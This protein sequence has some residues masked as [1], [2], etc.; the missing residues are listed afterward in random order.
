MFPVSLAGVDSGKSSTYISRTFLI[1]RKN[2]V[3]EDRFKSS[4]YIMKKSF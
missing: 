1:S 3:S 4:K 2:I